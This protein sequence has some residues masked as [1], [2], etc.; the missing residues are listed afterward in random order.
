MD[1]LLLVL[2]DDMLVIMDSRFHIPCAIALIHLEL[3]PVYKILD[4]EIKLGGNYISL[5][6][7]FAL[8]L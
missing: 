4:V 7:Y 8:Q 3:I 2:Q 1:W 5:P 6:T